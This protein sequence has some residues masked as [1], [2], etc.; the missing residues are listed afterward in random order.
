MKAGNSKKA[1]K[2]RER[3]SAIEKKNLLNDASEK[4]TLTIPYFFKKKMKK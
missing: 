2:A 4:R 3:K 1:A